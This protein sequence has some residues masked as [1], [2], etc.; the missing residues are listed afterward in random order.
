MNSSVNETRSIRWAQLVR[1]GLLRLALVIVVLAVAIPLGTLVS[2][3]NWSDAISII[4]LG[5]VVVAILVNPINGLLLWIILDPYARFWYLNVPMPTGI[6]DLSLGRLA[7]ACLCVVWLAQLAARKRRL[8]RFGPTEVFMLLFCIMV[9]PAVAAGFSGLNRTLQTLFDKFITTFLVF[10]LAKNLYEDKTALAKLSAALAVIEGYLIVLLVYEHV[11]G[12]APFY[13]AG[14]TT[15]YTQHLQKIVGLLGNAAYTATILAMIAPIALYNLVS[16]RSSNSRAFY[17]G[18]FALA[19]IGNFFCYNRGAWLAMII[20]ILVMAFFEPRYRR[21]LV[22][23]LVLAAVV[24][25]AYWQP[26]SE[27]YVI[28]ERLTNVNSIRFRVN[29]LEVSQKIIRE[30]LLFGVGFGNFSYYYTQYGGHWDLMAW[31]EPSPHN[32][33]ILIWTTMGLVVVLP[34]VLIFLSMLLEMGAMF[35]RSWRELGADRALLAS[36]WASIAAYMVSAAVAELY[37]NALS[38]LVL[39]LIT[40][41]IIGYVSHLRSS[42]AK[43]RVA[44]GPQEETVQA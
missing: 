19:V 34:Y 7:V 41:T 22:P 28:T 13:I 25:V 4:G 20:G 12:Q 3:P 16:S 18:M 40:G 42:A 27:S 26:L 5:G 9:I 23:L 32:T 2:S 36:G 21:L 24:G 39:F 8:R 35:R 44:N 29:M 38:A 33:Y 31:G 6:P 17:G 10:V 43:L 15:V 14:R 37:V 1:G 30:H 11:T